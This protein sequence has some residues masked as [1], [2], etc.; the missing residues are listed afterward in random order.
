[1]SVAPFPIRK[2]IIQRLGMGKQTA[3]TEIIAE[4]REIDNAVAALKKRRK[5]LIDLFNL[6]ATRGVGSPAIGY[7]VIALHNAMLKNIFYAHKL[8][9]LIWR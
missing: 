8:L 7:C 6:L 9:P 5:Y 1:M 3:D 2:R 4:I